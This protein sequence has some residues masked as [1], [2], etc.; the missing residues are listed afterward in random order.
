MKI[1]VTGGAGYIGSILV[2]TLLSKGHDVTVLDSMMYNQTSLLECCHNEKFEVINGDARNELLLK[3]LLND[4]DVI[5]PLAA[6]VGAPASKKNEYNT[7]STNRDAVVLLNKLRSK[8]QW[9]I[10]PT[11]NSGYGIG[12]EGIYCTEETP[13]RP[14]SLYGITKVEAE[15]ALLETE[16]VV[17][18]RLATVF[19]FS[20]RMRLDLLVNDFT[21]RAYTERYIVLFEAHFKRNYIHI[22]DVAKAFSFAIDNFE[23]MENQPYNVGLSSANLSKMELCLKIREQIP[24]FYITTSEFNNDPDKRNYIVSNEKIERLGYRPDYTIDHGI[25]E[26]IKGFSIINNNKFANI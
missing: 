2:P 16:N 3:S 6:I 21:Y 15:Q 19:G 8:N 17:T 10:F 22:L 26:L 18:L 12:Q 5:I 11:T 9:I 4:K 1:L 7:V 20:P 13:L 14:I 25:R 23:R 24:D